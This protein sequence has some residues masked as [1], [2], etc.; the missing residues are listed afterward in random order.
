M[1]GSPALL[2]ADWGQAK[3]ARGRVRRPRQRA[4]SAAREAEQP[5]QGS[6]F[7]S[8]LHAAADRIEQSIRERSPQAYARTRW[9]LPAGAALVHAAQGGGAGS[10]RLQWGESS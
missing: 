9:H 10:V 6:L 5:P 4:D 8:L 2:H 3:G 7:L 1:A